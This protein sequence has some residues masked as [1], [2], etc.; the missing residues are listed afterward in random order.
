MHGEHSSRTTGASS[1]PA[2]TTRNAPQSSLS[3]TTS[4]YHSNERTPQDLQRSR[5]DYNFDMA[6]LMVGGAA[7]VG[8]LIGWIG[9]PL[10]LV[11][12]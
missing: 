10:Y 11:L 5:G 12:K 8:I 1:P 3:W 9:W 4:N 2:A 6:P 7:I